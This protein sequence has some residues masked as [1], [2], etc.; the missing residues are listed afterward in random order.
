MPARTTLLL[1]KQPK[2]AAL[3]ILTQRKVLTPRWAPRI[4]NP[5]AQ[6]CMPLHSFMPGFSSYWKMPN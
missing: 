2:S 1:G 3:S 4:P 6:Q 5:L